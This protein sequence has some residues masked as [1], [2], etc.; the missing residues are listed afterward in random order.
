MTMT[1]SD[2]QKAPDPLPRNV[3]AYTRVLARRCLDM[4]GRPGSD[5]GVAVLLAQAFET[6]ISAEQRSGWWKL[7]L[8]AR[9]YIRRGLRYLCPSSFPVRAPCSL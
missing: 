6:N 9:G 1:S 2:T 3:E 8:A 5:V 4:Q 7:K